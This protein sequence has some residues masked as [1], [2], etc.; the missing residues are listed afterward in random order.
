MK[1]N[2]TIVLVNMQRTK[3]SVYL[4]FLFKIFANKYFLLEAS[5]K[6]IRWLF[7]VI[8]APK[9]DSELFEWSIKIVKILIYF[10]KKHSSHLLKI[11]AILIILRNTAIRFKRNIIFSLF[12]E[13]TA[14]RSTV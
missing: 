5:Q 1:I 6:I 13:R 9:I 3:R 14:T 2:Y 10:K 7:W 12:K 11:L 8:G 4:S